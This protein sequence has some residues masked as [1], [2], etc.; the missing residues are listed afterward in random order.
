MKKIC[1][2][3]VVLLTIFFVGN[4]KVFAFQVEGSG[5]LGAG[6][7]RTVDG[8]ST[9]YKQTT[10]ED[11]KMALFCTSH[12]DKSPA[13][14]N[15]TCTLAT[16]NQAWSLQAGAGVAAI[17]NAVNGKL[18]ND[19][20]TAPS[21]Q[22]MAAVFS[23]NQFLANKKEGGRDLTA[24]TEFISGSIYTT[25]ATEYLRLANA[26]YDAAVKPT[27]TFSSNELTFTLKDNKYVSNVVTITSSQGAELEVTAST[28]NLI[29]DNDKYSVEI[30][31]SAVEV[32]EVL[33]VSLNATATKS[34]DYAENYSCGT[35]TDT[36]DYNQNGNT[37]ET[38]NYQSVTPEK[39]KTTN[40][41]ATG[42][43]NGKIEIKTSLTIKKV[44]ENNKLL[45][46]VVLKVESK[47]NDYSETFT[48][49]DKEI[50]I[51]NLKF[52][53]YTITEVSTPV[54]YVKLKESE[55]VTISDNNL[56]ATVTLNNSLNRV[57]ISK[58]SSVDGKL[59]PGAVLQI[60]DEDGNVLKNDKDEKYEWTTDD[61]VHVI[62][63]LAPG[64]YY[65]VEISSPEGYALNDKKIEFTVDAE[66][67]VTKVEMKNDIEVKVPDT[68]SARSALLITISMFDIALGIGIIT[69]VK[70]NKTSE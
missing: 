6:F 58:I 35:Y 52:G 48:T 44:D 55:T 47:E 37:S 68:L 28:G 24:K 18:I 69:Y 62:Y 63:G 4:L 59:L 49:T 27:I 12:E 21:D 54:G 16:G 22:Y 60:Q 36:E 13:D 34:V 15:T 66:K 70:K 26:E 50:K 67:A 61:S 9:S 17:I 19:S 5:K 38:L 20:N 8:F 7:Y 45:P 42:S 64:T 51:E 3:L 33:N 40:L 23:I 46:G 56:N 1:K 29:K 57:E 14:A 53:K 25:Y 30:D 11:N 43:A 2:S 41:T 39:L 65:L 31:A 32:G 10:I